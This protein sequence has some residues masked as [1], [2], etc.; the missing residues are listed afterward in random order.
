MNLAEAVANARK[1]AMLVAAPDLGTVVAKGAD[2]V[3]WLNGLVTC[4][5]NGLAPGRAIYGLT[6]AKKGRIVSDLVIVNAGEALVMLIPRRL[7]D[8]LFASFEHYLVM[9]DVELAKGEDAVFF[10]HGPRA[11]EVRVEGAVCAEIDLTG[12]G[13]AVVICSP[14]FQEKIEKIT[15]SI[16][17]SVGD[18]AAWEAL[19]IEQGIPRFGRD[20][21]DSTYPQEASLEKRAVSF[22]KG[23]YLG[24]EV[25]CMLELRGHVKRKLVGV[26]LSAAA[27]AGASITDAEGKE[28]GQLTSV[29][30]GPTTN[31]HMGLAMIKRS[32]IAPGSVLRAGDATLH[33]R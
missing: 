9:E 22:D 29:A 20:F 7:R 32:H 10:V 14:E 5:L 19:R 23:C 27:P 33:V 18:D 13:G 4:E 17:G 25:V 24:Q 11:S 6:V 31:Q 8:D 26:T 12:L 15:E 21:D 1:T 30:F 16:G 2:R 3:S 28:I